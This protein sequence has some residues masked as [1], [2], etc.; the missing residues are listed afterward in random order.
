MSKLFY[1]IGAS[2]AGKDTLMTYART[3]INGEKPVLFAHRYITRQ[4][5][6]GGENHVYLTAEEFKL[7]AEAGFFA[8]FWES[9][10]K[11]YGVGTEIN[12]WLQ[13]GFSVVVNGS[14]QYLPIAKQLYPDL[15]VVMICASPEVIA[16][17]LAGRGRES[18]EEIEKRIKRSDEISG[19]LSGCLHIEN[20]DSIES[21]GD[22]LIDIITLAKQ[23]EVAEK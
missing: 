16:Q 1:V 21:A 10:D 7:R 4:P 19:D 14:R 3:K 12:K 18:A 23:F 11:H 2:G 6:A 13:Q 9:H 5:D 17:R 15:V 22:R 8:L 20:N